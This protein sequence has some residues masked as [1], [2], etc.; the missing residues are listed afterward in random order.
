MLWFSGKGSEFSINFSGPI[1]LKTAFKKD[2]FQRKPKNFQ[3]QPERSVVDVFQ[4]ESGALTGGGDISDRGLGQP[5]DAGFYTDPLF[6]FVH[7]I[8][9]FLCKNIRPR[10]H[11]THV[12]FEHIEQLGKFIK[13]G[14]AEKL[15][16]SSDTRIAFSGV[17]GSDPIRP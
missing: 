2:L 15:S 12:A 4:I 16:H 6:L 3:V 17:I 1:P 7:G 9:G 13:T 8:V 11:Q 14:F 10:A 5:G